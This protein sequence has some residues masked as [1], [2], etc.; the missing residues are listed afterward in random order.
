MQVFDHDQVDALN[1]LFDPKFRCAWE[2]YERA[3]GMVTIPQHPVT[4]DAIRV[5]RDRRTRAAKFRAYTE[6]VR[7]ALLWEALRKL[8][9]VSEQTPTVHTE[10]SGNTIMAPTEKLKSDTFNF[11]IILRA[12]EALV[13]R[14]LLPKSRYYHY[15]V[16]RD[17]KTLEPIPYRVPPKIVGT[18]FGVVD[19]MLATGGSQDFVLTHLEQN[20]VQE[21]VVVCIFAAVPGV[22]RI[23]EKHP[24][25][26][27]VCGALDPILDARG[28]IVDGCGDFGDRH[29][30][31]LD[32]DAES[33][34]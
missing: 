27:I 16:K 11:A 1:A 8:P 25:V 29:S 12:G 24:H 21:C 2:D 28:F 18:Q 23:K 5:L 26:R 4:A 20:G 7:D 31:T 33:A 15:G 30:E 22:I 6:I 17:E 34:A 32:E 14:R 19:P 10:G 9:L 3:Y 13:N